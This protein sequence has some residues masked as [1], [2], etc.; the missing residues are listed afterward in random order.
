MARAMI[1]RCYGIQEVPE[2]EWFCAKCSSAAAKVPGGANEATFC[3]Q[4]CPFDYG[5]LKKTDRGGWAHVICALYI[6]E[7]RFGNVHSMEPV[8]LSDVPCDK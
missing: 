8:I 1:D 7:V 4:L 2:G 5:A 3:C 6:P